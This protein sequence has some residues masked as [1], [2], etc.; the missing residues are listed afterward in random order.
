MT[1]KASSTKH[2]RKPGV[3]QVSAFLN[4]EGSEAE[5]IA[6]QQAVDERTYDFR[7]AIAELAA[8]G[9][10]ELAR[11]GFRATESSPRLTRERTL[12]ELFDLCR[13][14][15]LPYDKDVVYYASTQVLA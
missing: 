11:M 1:R 9:I 8:L 10:A 5:P 14:R 3:I 2:P 6:G 13:T 4:A 12:L 7:A 15:S